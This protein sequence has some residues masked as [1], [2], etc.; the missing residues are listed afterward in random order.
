MLVAQSP[1]YSANLATKIWIT[2]TKKPAMSFCKHFPHFTK[3]KIKIK[4]SNHKRP[5]IQEYKKNYSASLDKTQTENTIN[6]GCIKHNI[7]K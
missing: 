7:K 3:P 2:C 4:M 1:A 5:K 6:K